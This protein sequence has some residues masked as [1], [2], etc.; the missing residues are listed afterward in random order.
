MSRG[1][2]IGS[3]AVQAV[4]EVSGATQQIEQQREQA[5]AIGELSKPVGPDNLE[6]VKA[7]NDAAA[8]ERRIRGRAATLLTGGRGVTGGTSLLKQTLMGS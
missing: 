3:P 1:F 8:R 7:A 4:A 5:R 6:A 2:K